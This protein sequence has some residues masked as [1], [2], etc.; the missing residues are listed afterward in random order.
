MDSTV[1]RICCRHHQHRHHHHHHH[2]H[3]DTCRKLKILRLPGY[4]G[5]IPGNQW[6][7]GPFGAVLINVDGDDEVEDNDSYDFP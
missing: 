7:R 4:C 1:A 6:I 2:H 3:I 5:T